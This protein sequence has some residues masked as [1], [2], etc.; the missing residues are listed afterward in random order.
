MP[1]NALD[2]ICKTML[3]HPEYREEK[4]TFNKMQDAM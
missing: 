3:G 4:C 1:E 2:V